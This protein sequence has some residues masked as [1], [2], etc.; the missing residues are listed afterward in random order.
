LRAAQD[1]ATLTLPRLGALRFVVYGGPIYRAFVAT[2]RSACSVELNVYI[3]QKDL[4]Q[5]K[6]RGARWP[7][8][9]G[10]LS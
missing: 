3:F 9:S 4:G 6:E 1:V 7:S 5:N 8:L 10:M 2:N